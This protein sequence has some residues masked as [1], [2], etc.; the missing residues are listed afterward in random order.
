MS[1]S[2]PRACWL[3]ARRALLML[4]LA[5]ALPG[6]AQP[7]ATS[8]AGSVLPGCTEKDKA[9]WRA[10]QAQKGVPA[11]GLSADTLG[12]ALVSCLGSPDPEMRDGLAYEL[13][14]S[15]MR[16]GALSDSALRAT[17]RT[18]IEGLGSGLGQA[19][20][21]TVFRRTFSALVLSEVVRRDNL[22]PFLAPE[23]AAQVL[24]AAVR[25]LEEERDLRGLSDKLGWMHGVAHGADL[26]WR[27]AM[28]P[29]LEQAGLER[30][31]Q[32]VA[33][34]VAPSEH[35][36]I[37]NESDRLAR[38][39]GAVMRRGL[40]P[41][42]TFARWLTEV[43]TPKGMASWEEAFRREKGMAQ[44]HNTKQFLRALHSQWTLEKADP[45]R[46]QLIPPLVSE[47]QKVSL[48]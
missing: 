36:Y 13:L 43:A 4:C 24:A 2:L 32:A 8:K 40:V 9:F 31:L 47:L 27:L 14:T 39:V 34:K 20:K 44:L 1:P 26:L 17:T 25:Y 11:T 12:P 30:I 19:G 41:S 37:H 21:E 46:G 22:Q 3:L 42:D 35:A 28:S 5:A 33:S 6:S 45:A 10:L 38:V 29:R 16:S 15:W 7:L 48:L 18:L 23:E